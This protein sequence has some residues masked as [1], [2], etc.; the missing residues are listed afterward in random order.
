MQEFITM[1]FYALNGLSV[2]HPFILDSLP[3]CPFAFS[4]S[5]K[6]GIAGKPWF[7]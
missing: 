4:T 5:S 7:E 1:K 3:S 6:S 2:E